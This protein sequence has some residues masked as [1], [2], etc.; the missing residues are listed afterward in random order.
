MLLELDGCTVR[1][2]RA[3]DAPSL[4]R[5]ADDRDVARNLR[6]GFPHPYT[7]ADADAFL[8]MALDRN[9]E[10]LFAVD[11]DGEA[12]GGIGYSP[13]ADVERLSAEIGYWL[14]R[15][16]WGRGITTRVLSAVTRYA[17]ES[18]GL[19]RVYALPFDWNPASARVLEKAGYVLEGTLK[20]AVIKD[21]K[22]LDQRMYA[23][24]VD[25]PGVVP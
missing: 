17:I 9:P 4:A 22:I 16:F 15:P 12:V 14:A 1:S 25:R 19:V 18:H 21:G 20:R 11:V 2:W 24:V 23:Y 5:Y 7:R 6:D 3:A 8:A 13:R 10:T